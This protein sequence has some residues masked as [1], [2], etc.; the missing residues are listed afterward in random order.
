MIDEHALTWRQKQIVEV[1][2]RSIHERGYPP[3]V[4][5]I[6]HAVGL[7]SPSTVKHHLD[8][9]ERAGI[10]QRDAGRPRAIDLR[11]EQ[12]GASV[13]SPLTIPVALAESDSVVAPLV[14]R[15]A[16]G[17]PVTAEQLVEDTFALPVRF[18][19]TGK[20]F[21]LEV[22]GDSM[23]DAAICDGDFVVV[24]VQP[25]ADNGTIVAAMIEGEATI[26]VFSRR[27][28]HVWL[29]PR[30]DD[31]A[32]IPGDKAVILGRVVTVIRSL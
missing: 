31:Y 17:A 16:A 29:L 28:G 30:N 27:E 10:L 9:L 15:V 18:T 3:S 25:T 5:E 2:R 1:V 6:G 21:V 24:R 11:G 26:K 14:G 7:A 20:L 19:G 32:P 13:P 12:A 8:A 22:S 23:I 4:R